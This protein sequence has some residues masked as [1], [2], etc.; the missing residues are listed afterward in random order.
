MELCFDA[1]METQAL[2]MMS[3]TRMDA[4]L[5]AHDCVFFLYYSVFIGWWPAKHIFLLWSNYIFV[6]QLIYKPPY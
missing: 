1:T 2:Q 4:K 5:Q 6:K 3:S